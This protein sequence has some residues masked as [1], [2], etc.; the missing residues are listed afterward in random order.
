M[1]PVG[2]L[3]PPNYAPQVVRNGESTSEDLGVTELCAAMS[4]N[5]EFVATVVK[6]V[7]SASLTDPAVIRY[8]QGVLQECLEKPELVRALYDI[9]TEATTAR[10]WTVGRGR[11]PRSKLGLGLQPLEEL[12]GHLR[13]LRQYCE[14]NAG[15]SRSE[16]F[17]RFRA[18]LSEQ[19]DD[20]YLTKLDSL[21]PV[22]F[23]ENGVLLSAA[24]GTGNKADRVMLHEPPKTSKNAKLSLFSRRSG[25]SFEATSDY[26][27]PNDPLAAVI[28]PA[29]DSVAEVVSR[30]ADK[31]QAF[32]RQ[33]RTELGFYIGCL[34]LHERLGRMGAPICLPQPVVGSPA[35]QC[36]DLRDP[37]LCL[38]SNAV[39]GNDIDDL[40]S[41]FVVVTGA[42]S[43][44]KSTFLRSV[45]LAQLMMQAGMFVVAQSFASDVRAGVFTHFVRGEDETMKH[46]R[47]DEELTRMRSITDQLRPGGMLLC[48]EPFASTN[49]R[50]AAMIA[51]PIFS[52]L[53]DSGTKVVLVTHL[54]DFVRQRYADERAT[55][56]FLHAERASD[57]GRTY[58]LTVGAPESTSYGDDIFA[59]VFGY[60]PGE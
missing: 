44:G 7:V 37:S 3:H 39:V 34:N 58:R 5:D 33:L 8:R 18:T 11:A 10:R 36:R 28:E 16:G 20:D 27:L 56:L 38:S 2:L 19:L 26:E 45:G 14:R 12:V 40:G 32:F 30:A 46:G 21:L 49:D 48:N 50:E 57:G 6:S 35:L 9:A 55:D 59:R 15:Q 23:F 1:I 17:I 54:F 31:V 41:T 42:N 24:L 4:C 25:G 47:L 53:V 22:L 51:A 29:L 60:R 43:G 13:R 52:A